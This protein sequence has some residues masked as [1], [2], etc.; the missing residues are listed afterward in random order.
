[1][2][3]LLLNF[4]TPRMMVMKNIISYLVNSLVLVLVV[5]V[6][7]PVI[8]SNLINAQLYVGLDGRIS[9]LICSC[10]TISVL[11]DT[12]VFRHTN[13][14]SQQ[15]ILTSC[16]CLIYIFYWCVVWYWLVIHV[17]STMLAQLCVYSDIM[18]SLHFYSLQSD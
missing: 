1:M 10:N 9:R 18:F 12:S 5:L 6:H 15:V 3:Q 14:L 2:T 17:T 7:L 11:M 8:G 13:R 16:H 4:K